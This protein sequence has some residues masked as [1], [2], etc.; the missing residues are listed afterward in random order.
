MAYSVVNKDCPT[1]KSPKRVKCSLKQQEQVWGGE[2]CVKGL[3]YPSSKSTSS[4]QR[5]NHINNSG[6]LWDSWGK[7][8]PRPLDNHSSL[9]LGSFALSLI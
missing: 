7:D 9:L 1:E 8:K 6:L 5:W 3:F 2:V 4:L